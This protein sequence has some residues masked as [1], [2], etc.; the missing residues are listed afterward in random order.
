VEAIKIS[1]VMDSPDEWNQAAGRGFEAKAKELGMEP[2][3]MNPQSDLKT[4]L[5]LLQSC[6]SQKL[7][8]FQ[9]LALDNAA[10]AP[11]CDKAMEAGLKVISCFKIEGVGEGIYIL[12]YDHQ[13]AAYTTGDILGKTLGGKGKVAIIGGVPGA[14]NTIERT[15]GFKKV[16]EEK[17]PEIEVVAEIACSWDRSKAQAAADDILTK[18]KDLAGFFVMD[19]GMG[20]GVAQALEATGKQPG[21]VK[22]ATINGS[23]IGLQKIKEGWFLCTVQCDGTFYGK[24]VAQ[25]FADLRD[26]KTIENYSKWLGDTITKE[27]ADKYNPEW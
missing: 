13:L 12:D 10:V 11:V 19:E 4:Q 18:N 8:G 6:I 1:Y 15:A 17:Y 24:L 3:V 27:N 22:I 2:I 25:T 23:K 5:D 9:V 14:T 16:L 20:V 7:Y 26:G 21:D